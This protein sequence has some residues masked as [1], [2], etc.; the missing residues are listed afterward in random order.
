MDVLDADPVRYTATSRVKLLEP[1]VW[2]RL[3]VKGLPTKVTFVWKT[4][5]EVQDLP[6]RL[7]RMGRASPGWREDPG[8]LAYAG[9]DGWLAPDRF[10]RPGNLVSL[11]KVSRWLTCTRYFA[12]FD[13]FGTSRAAVQLVWHERTHSDE[14]ARFFRLLL[15]A[16]LKGSIREA[17]CVADR[18]RQVPLIVLIGGCSASRPR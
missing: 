13:S 4:S 7:S 1:R 9:F 17:K 6:Q 2:Y 5:R 16:A 8:P 14:G 3:L 12:G 11:S 15:V 18:G 10:R